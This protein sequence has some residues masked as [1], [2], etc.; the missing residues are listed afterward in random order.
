MH[1]SDTGIGRSSPRGLDLHVMVMENVQIYNEEGD[2]VG[3]FY[4][5]TPPIQMNNLV[6]IEGEVFVRWW[7]DA[8]GID[9]ETTIE[10][11]KQER[12]EPLYGSYMI[13][14]NDG[15]LGFAIHTGNKAVYA[16]SDE[17]VAID[18]E[19]VYSIANSRWRYMSVQ[20]IDDEGTTDLLY[21]TG[22]IYCTSEQCFFS[23]KEP[24]DK[25]RTCCSKSGTWNRDG[26]WIEHV[27]GEILPESPAT[28]MDWLSKM[29]KEDS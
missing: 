21:N 16:Y 12:G 28:E 25:Q 27:K 26:E 6:V 5:A 19:Y 23:H 11:L 24:T 10:D 29:A 18:A 9:D 14:D 15:D 20:S 3:T 1:I 8:N 17:D 2:L 4:Y 7:A 13:I 22:F